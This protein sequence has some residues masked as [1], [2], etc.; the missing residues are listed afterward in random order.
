MFPF[1]M[2]YLF[3][4]TKPR[5]HSSTREEISADACRH[6]CPIS[7]LQQP[8]TYI[9][10][11]N[12]IHLNQTP[13]AQNKLNIFAFHPEAWS[14]LECYLFFFFFLWACTLSLSPRHKT[15]RVALLLKHLQ[16]HLK[17]GLHYSE[18]LCRNTAVLNCTHKLHVMQTFNMKLKHCHK[19]TS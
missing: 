12:I 19:M 18:A 14:R 16:K 10:N 15:G 5:A 17:L 7:Q 2:H 3:Y 1:W 9:L 11:F 4:S 8:V 6:R 13:I